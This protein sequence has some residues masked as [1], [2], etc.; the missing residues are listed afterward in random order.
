[1]LDETATDVENRLYEYLAAA[2]R[3]EVL[4]LEELRRRDP[5]AAAAL[6]EFPRGRCALAGRPA[7]VRRHPDLQQLG[8]LRT[9]RVR[10]HSPGVR[11]CARHWRR[12]RTSPVCLAWELERAQATGGDQGD[13]LCR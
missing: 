1:M 10:S 11:V 4:D 3:G 6:E 13:R 8:R 2:E 9:P 5:E 7:A 12:R